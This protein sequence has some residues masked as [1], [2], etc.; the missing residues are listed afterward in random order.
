MTGAFWVKTVR[1]GRGMEGMPVMN[2]VHF[3]IFPVALDPTPCSTTDSHLTITMVGCQCL[4]DISSLS[5]IFPS[6]YLSLTSSFF[7]GKS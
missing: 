3:A 1:L 7:Y 4:A 2:T 5:L 6:I